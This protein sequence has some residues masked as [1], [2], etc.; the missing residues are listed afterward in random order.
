M[1]LIEYFKNFK[2]FPT[3]DYKFNLLDNENDSLGR[4]NLRTEHSDK[5]ISKMTDK[6]FIGKVENDKFRI[7][8]S[9]IG[10]GA[11][12]VMDGS[13]SNGK[14]K[15]NMTVNRPFGILISILYCFPIIAFIVQRLIGD[16]NQFGFVYSLFVIV[17]QF[18]IIRF[19][20][21]D[22][23]FKKLA[24]TSIYK[25]RDVVNFEMIG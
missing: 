21:L 1:V 4:L 18:L 23:A 2:L 11:V 14:C 7:I 20:V 8:T 19:I 16:S 24:R 25:L 13:V 15:V 12:W 3:Y 17:V 22:F 9:E 10:K 6:S 5:L